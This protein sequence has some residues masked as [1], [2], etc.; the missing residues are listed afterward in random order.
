MTSEKDTAVADSTVSE[1]AAWC[2]RAL[3]LGAEAARPLAPQ[4]VVTADWVRLKCQFGCDG[5]G[6]CRTCPPHSPAPEQTRRLLNGFS[7]AILLRVGPH[8]GASG[9]YSGT[10]R[11]AAAG[12]ERELFLAG[13]YKAWAMGNGPCEICATCDTATPCVDPEHAR[14]SME[15]CGIDVFATVRNAG[16]EIEVVADREDRYRFFA[17]VLVD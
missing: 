3:E 2:E 5:Y 4:L 1:L 13:H 15:A 8:T 14:P 7:R 10:L 6:S 11:K 12:L 16:W 17:L 9:G